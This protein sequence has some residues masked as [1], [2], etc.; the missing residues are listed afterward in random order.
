M[1]FLTEIAEQTA[2]RLREGLRQERWRGTM[3]GV[4]QLASPETQFPPVQAVLP[5]FRAVEKAD[6]PK[7]GADWPVCGSLVPTR[8]G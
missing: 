5:W 6:D 8:A 7:A 1:I 2:A 3:P 4:R